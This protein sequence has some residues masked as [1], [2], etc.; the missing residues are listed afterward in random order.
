M[1]DGSDRT[2]LEWVRRHL[3]DDANAANVPCDSAQTA[4]AVSNGFLQRVGLEFRWKDSFKQNLSYPLGIP[5]IDPDNNV[6]GS[7]GIDD[8]LAH[9]YDAQLRADAVDYPLLNVACG[10]FAVFLY[11]ENAA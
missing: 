6:N 9:F 3:D 5:I 2:P 8:T 10:T 4:H 7:G 1:Y 11:A